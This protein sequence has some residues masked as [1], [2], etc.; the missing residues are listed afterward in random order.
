MTVTEEAGVFRY[1]VYRV[2]GCWCVW[3]ACG[4]TSDKITAS[5]QPRLD[6]FRWSRGRP[7]WVGFMYKQGF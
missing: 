1:T 2:C 4:S 5:T 6:G 3:K 7:S